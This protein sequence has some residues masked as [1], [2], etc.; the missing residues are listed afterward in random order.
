MVKG[1][2]SEMKAVS[3]QTPEQTSYYLDRVFD[4]SVPIPLMD[5]VRWETVLGSFTFIYC[6]CEYMQVP[7]TH[8]EVRRQLLGVHC[9]FPSR[10]LLGIIQ[11]IR[12]GGT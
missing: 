8:V 7:H 11:V 2:G 10:W 9:V 3:I 6:V 12:L 5:T 1:V 4:G